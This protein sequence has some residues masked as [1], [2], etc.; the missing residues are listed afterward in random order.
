MRAKEHTERIAGRAIELWLDLIARSR[1]SIGV[2]L[3]WVFIQSNIYSPLVRIS[4][5]KITSSKSTVIIGIG[6]VMAVALVAA[7]CIVLLGRRP[8]SNPGVR[9]HF[10]SFVGSNL[11][12]SGSISSYICVSLVLSGLTGFSLGFNL[13]R[14]QST[15]HHPLQVACS[16]GLGR[17]GMSW[18]GYTCRILRTV[19]KILFRW[20]PVFHGVQFVEP[21][22]IGFI[23]QIHAPMFDC[24]SE[25]MRVVEICGANHVFQNS[26]TTV[27]FQ[28]TCLSICPFQGSRLLT[29]L[30][31][32]EAQWRFN[33]ASFWFDLSIFN[34]ECTITLWQTSWGY[35]L[36]GLQ[37][38]YIIS[39]MALGRFSIN[40][41]PW[42]VLKQT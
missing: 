13:H 7:F 33:F 21:S 18:Q 11:F 15:P 20:L 40:I 19:C 8:D 6:D 24:G 12:I 29:N 32:V 35:L 17:L 23:P 41:S 14:H 42:S 3:S 34:F 5:N 30:R 39:P 27:C 10:L 26:R 38:W 25:V 22:P 37:S 9:Q 1:L 2:L 4:L 16:N 31:V 28:P 36:T